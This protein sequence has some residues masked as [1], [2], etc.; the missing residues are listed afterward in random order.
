MTRSLEE[1]KLELSML[2]RG[3]R[4]G[5]SRPHKLVMLLAVLDMI[6]ALDRFDNRIAF[7]A[8]LIQRF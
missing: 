4:A 5:H 6:D 7:D 3:S 8:D 1:L 2:R